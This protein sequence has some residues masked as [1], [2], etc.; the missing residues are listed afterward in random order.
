MDQ[1]PAHFSL[2]HIPHQHFVGTGLAAG[3]GLPVMFAE[4]QY[5]FRWQLPL[6]SVPAA[7]ARTPQSASQAGFIMTICESAFLMNSGCG[8]SAI[9]LRS[10]VS[11]VMR[12]S[13][14]FGAQPVHDLTDLCIRRK[15]NGFD[16]VPQ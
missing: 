13:P 7:S 10:S 1:Q 12:D 16:M 2:A 3:E 6:P 15:E 14:C 8:I 4:L 11:L 9:M 5:L